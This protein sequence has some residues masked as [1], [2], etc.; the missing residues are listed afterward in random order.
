MGRIQNITFVLFE[1]NDVSEFNTSH[2]LSESDNAGGFW[3]RNITIFLSEN[4]DNSSSRIQTSRFFFPKTIMSQNSKHVFFPKPI[5]LQ[6]SGYKPS[7]CFFS[8]SIK[9]QNTKHHEVSFRKQG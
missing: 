7:M 8:K 2:F 3:I 4:K 9:L 1:S 5:I 6:V